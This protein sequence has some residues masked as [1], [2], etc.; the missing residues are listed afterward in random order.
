MRRSLWGNRRSHQIAAQAAPST[1]LLGGERGGLT[2]S[3][4]DL[5]NSPDEYSSSRVG[6]RRVVF[7][8]TNG[9]RALIRARQARR[10]LVAAL[11]NVGAVA[12]VLRA[13]SG[14]VHI[15]CAGTDGAVTLEDVLCAGAIARRLIGSGPEFDGR[16]DATQMVLNL[17]QSC[18]QNCDRVL[19]LL[20][21]SRGGRN[22]I[23]CGLDAD[24]A[25]CAKE[26]R[27]YIVPELFQADWQVRV[28]SLEPTVRTAATVQL[29]PSPPAGEGSE[30][31][32][33]SGKSA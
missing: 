24:I 13:E 14:A 10:V 1:V 27:F 19:E 33:K 12:K 23:E 18:G 7:T 8:T 22:L 2:I 4:F 26:D 30:V 25:W 16:D 32:G 20:R 28:A 31:R 17:Y 5:G 9:T 21:S 15:V 11:A 3:G 6:G 29:L